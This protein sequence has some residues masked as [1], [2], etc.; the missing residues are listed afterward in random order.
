[1][2]IEILEDRSEAKEI[3]G[4]IYK[5]TNLVNGKVYIGLTTLGLEK[6]KKAHFGNA[7]NDRLPDTYFYRALKK[8]GEDGF[9]WEIID[10]SENPKELNEKE[11]Y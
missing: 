4:V 9:C 1:M 2:T 6:R 7:N 8:Y 11:I 5:A 3:D 10:T